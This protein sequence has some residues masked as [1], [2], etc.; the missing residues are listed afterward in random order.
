MEHNIILADDHK[1]FLEG[2]V[3][4]LE[5]ETTLHLLYYA[6]N[7]KLVMNYLNAHPELEVDLVITDIAM[8][9]TDGILLNRFI[10]ETR[11]ATK[12]MVVSMHTDTNMV[13]ALVQNDVD[14]YLSKNAG[15]D[16]FL[17]AI[18]TILKGEK[19]FSESVKQAYMNSV[20]RK[21]K[22]TMEMLSTREKE[23]LKLIAQEY[24]TQE[25]ADK[26]YLSKHTIESYRKTLL[27]KLKVRNLAGLTRYAIKLGLLEN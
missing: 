27:S 9:E 14:G 20:F 4:L 12:T 5:K 6:H 22:D 2:L 18:H 26:L 1:L 16:E 10:K 15:A 8:P 24:T 13:D 25:I 3:Q 17:K 23:V 7:G 21:E 11:P 19:Y